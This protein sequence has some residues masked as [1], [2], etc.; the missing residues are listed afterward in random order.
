MFINWGCSPPLKYSLEI[1]LLQIFKHSRNEICTDAWLI[2]L[3]T[4]ELKFIVMPFFQLLQE[5]IKVKGLPLHSVL[6]G[7]IK[8]T[9]LLR[10][11]QAPCVCKYD[12]FQ[13][14]W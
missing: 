5:H 8:T 2:I 11:Y 7:N 4:G 1:V 10:Q 14:L 13:M 12:W 3:V 9:C 6:S